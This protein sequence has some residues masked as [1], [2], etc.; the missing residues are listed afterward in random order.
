MFQFVGR[1]AKVVQWMVVT[2]G[3][4]VEV[5]FKGIILGFRGNRQRFYSVLVLEK[6]GYFLW[7]KGEGFD[8]WKWV[9]REIRFL[10]VRKGFIY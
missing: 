7:N 8:F 4:K 10:G 9:F 5:S 6:F 2:L 3:S 1:T